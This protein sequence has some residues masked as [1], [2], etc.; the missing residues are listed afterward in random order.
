MTTLKIENRKNT[1]KKGLE[2]LLP[3]LDGFEFESDI[4]MI[5]GDTFFCEGDIGGDEQ[6]VWSDEAEIRIKDGRAVLCGWC[7][8]YGYQPQE[9]RF[10]NIV[11][12][13]FAGAVKSL[14]SAISKYNKLAVEKDAEIEKFM[15]LCK[16]Y[17]K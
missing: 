7:E 15:N 3:L 12:I 17:N 13:D 11:K 8:Q 2:C 14:E 4:K 5:T 9:I 10:N 6:Y 1:T 16:E